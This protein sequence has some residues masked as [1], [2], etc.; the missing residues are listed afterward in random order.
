MSRAKTHPN[1]VD[2]EIRE[3]SPFD[4]QLLNTIQQILEDELFNLI[5]SIA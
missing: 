3:G 2:D 4:I 5:R 1:N